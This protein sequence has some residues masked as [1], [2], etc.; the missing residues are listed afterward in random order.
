[1]KRVLAVA[2]IMCLGVCAL[3]AA[4]YT[5]LVA[6]YVFTMMSALGFVVFAASLVVTVGLI[7]LMKRVATYAG[8]AGDRYSHRSA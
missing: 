3:A 5:I 7:A 4:A 2:A 8:I 1:M 6:F